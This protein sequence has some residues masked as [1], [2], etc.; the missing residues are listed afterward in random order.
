MGDRVHQVNKR[1]AYAFWVES[2]TNDHDGKYYLS[3]QAASGESIVQIFIFITCC[4]IW[5]G[6]ILSVITRRAHNLRNSMIM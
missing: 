2:R 5:N 6:Q 3:S 1:V 4:I